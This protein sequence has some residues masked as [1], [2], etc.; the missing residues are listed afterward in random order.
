M[1]GG[2]SRRRDRERKRQTD[3]LFLPASIH[4]TKW[5]GIGPAWVT[6]LLL[7]VPLYPGGWWEIGPVRVMC[8]LWGKGAGVPWVTAQPRPCRVEEGRLCRGGVLAGRDNTST[9]GKWMA[10]CLLFRKPLLQSSALLMPDK[11][12][13]TLFGI[14]F[15]GNTQHKTCDTFLKIALSFF[16]SFFLYLYCHTKGTFFTSFYTN[17]S[18]N[19]ALPFLSSKS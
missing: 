15:F 4:K 16:K 18:S 13:F 17:N 7:D 3:T 10:E 8:F 6:F 1:G 11:W 19:S 5:K 14:T 12:G 9:P 2:V